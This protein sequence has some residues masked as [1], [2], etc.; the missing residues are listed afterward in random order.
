MIINKSDMQFIKKRKINW[1]K[2]I[3]GIIR[4][5]IL[6]NIIMRGEK[7]SCNCQG[8]LNKAKEIEAKERLRYSPVLITNGYIPSEWV[9]PIHGYKKR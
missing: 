8:M 1:R 6:S 3:P 7:E 5:I 4:D 9:C 2:Y